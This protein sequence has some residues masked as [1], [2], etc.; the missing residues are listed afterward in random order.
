MTERD[1]TNLTMHTMAQNNISAL[2][3]FNTCL[4]AMNMIP[5]HFGYTWPKMNSSS[6]KDS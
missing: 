1:Q 2:V 3:K 6:F 4:S 5:V